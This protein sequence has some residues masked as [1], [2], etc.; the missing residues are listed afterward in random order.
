MDINRK[1]ISSIICIFMI[2]LSGLMVFSSVA[3]GP[4][5]IDCR[6]LT[7]YDVMGARLEA[8]EG[9]HDWRLK[10]HPS[11]LEYL[12]NVTAE[13]V[14]YVE[15]YVLNPREATE[16]SVDLSTNETVAIYLVYQVT[17][18]YVEKFLEIPHD[19]FYRSRFQPCVCMEV[20]AKYLEAIAE[21][22]FV[23]CI[24]VGPTEFF[25]E[26]LN[27]S[28]VTSGSVTIEQARTYNKIKYVL[29]NKD[30][31]VDKMQIAIIDNGY[32]KTDSL[33]NGE[34]SDNIAYH[35]DFHFDDSGVSDG[36]NEHGTT[37]LDLL[38]RAFGDTDSDPE[39]P[40]PMYE[41]EEIYYVLKTDYVR[42]AT[43]EAIEWCLDNDPEVV[44]MS[45]GGWDW[46][47][48]KTICQSWWC[49]LF[50]SGV[51]SG[52]TWVAATGNDGK[53]DKVRYPSQCYWVI[54]VGAYEDLS[55]GKAY[56]WSDSNYGT[57]IYAEWKPQGL[58]VY[59]EYCWNY[60]H[61]NEFKPNIY[62]AGAITGVGEGTSL[63]T[64]LAAACIAL[65]VYSSGADP[66]RDQG[67]VPGY[68]NLRSAVHSCHTY[69]VKPDASSQN[70]DV[71]NCLILW[72]AFG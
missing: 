64:P 55:G 69:P 61:M 48:S 30:S 11:D 1:I 66:G 63:A 24:R 65:G 20:E 45:F 10:V 21:L 34:A 6:R 27:E 67:W 8:Y 36:N 31:T 28:I 57:V 42:G 5:V 62:D 16:Y 70:G 18:E 44:S 72:D 41:D 51:E 50:K 32:D 37:C 23:Y 46:W 54:S 4:K 15:V 49:D 38:A 22:P 56:R 26:T 14:V 58:Y 35:W 12:E 2:L 39:T 60:N 47:K 29:Q 53:E 17:K 25:V 9:T 43:R 71:M 59:C 33:L 19:R 40:D 52:I 68:S 3:K 7:F 13:T